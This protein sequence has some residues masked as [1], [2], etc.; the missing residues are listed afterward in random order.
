MYLDTNVKEVAEAKLGRSIPEPDS[1][2]F[3]TLVLELYDQDPAL[4]ESLQS[5]VIFEQAGDPRDAA[6][7]ADA[8][9]Q[10]KQTALAFAFQRRDRFT[11]E[12]VED[13]NKVA[14]WVLLAFVLCA[15]AFFW[16]QRASTASAFRQP[17]SAQRA[18]A[19]GA[20]ASSA[21]G[22]SSG[23]ET[24][25]AQAPLE[26]ARASFNLSASLDEFSAA[27]ISGG[28]GDASPSG[29]APTAAPPPAPAPAPA[30]EA[31]PLESAI[32]L[33]RAETPNETVA[34]ARPEQ[35]GPGRATQHAAAGVLFGCCLSRGCVR[36]RNAGRW[37]ADPA[38]PSPFSATRLPRVQSP[39][40][41]QG[42]A[43]TDP[44]QQTLD[45]PVP[46]LRARRSRSSTTEHGGTRR[47]RLRARR[48]ARGELRNE[49]SDAARVSR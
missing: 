38:Q 12:L 36:K 7:K 27:Q 37:Q 29:G 9:A 43:Q 5:G 34:F 3:D 13:R 16:Y 39:P 33:E 49:D 46:F 18:S 42:D 15:V 26:P 25:G 10:R 35:E 32:V 22:A 47:S 17:V 6:R 41:P 14:F 44:F 28:A 23:G 45:T 19:Q 31:E 8:Q 20:G 21:A 4:A 1:P 11:G 24:G 30:P 48:D 2:E 40:A